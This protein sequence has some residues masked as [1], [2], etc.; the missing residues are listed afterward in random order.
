MNYSKNTLIVTF[1]DRIRVAD[2]Q[3]AEALLYKAK[4]FVRVRHLYRFSHSALV[5]V[6]DNKL[7]EF[8]EDMK[9]YDD[10]ERCQYNF[11]LYPCAINQQIASWSPAFNWGC[12]HIRSLH[13]LDVAP[14][15]G[16]GVKVAMIDSGMAPHPLLPAP[17]FT[18]AA[19]FTHL[20]PR[21]AQGN[22][23][24]ER[25]MSQ[26]L[27]LES[28]PSFPLLPDARPSDQADFLIR[29]EDQL[30]KFHLQ[31]WK[32]WLP[33]GIQWYND[34]ATA[35]TKYLTNRTASTA[36]SFKA[37]LL[38]P[39]PLT[40]SHAL[41]GELRRIST[42]SRSFVGETLSIEDT[43]GHGTQ[44]AGIIAGRAGAS[45]VETDP[46]KKR[47]LEKYET[48]VLGIVPNAEL[49]ILK[50]YDKDDVDNST[51][52]SLIRALEYG[53]EQN[54]DIVFCGLA[55]DTGPKGIDTKTAIALDRTINAL[56]QRNVFVVC[57]AGNNSKK[58][59]ELPA[60]CHSS[61]AISAVTTDSW[62]SILFADYSNSAG[63]REKVDFAAFG[64][65]ESL[66]ALT[67]GLD[68]GYSRVHGTS[69][70]AAIATG[71]IARDISKAYLAVRKGEYEDEMYKGVYNANQPSVPLM[72]PYAPPSGNPVS[73]V[74]PVAII[75]EARKK[76]LPINPYPPALIGSGL[77]V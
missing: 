47:E 48:D 45:S 74:K 51:V 63:P 65:D 75:R 7:D 77:I 42:R 13:G 2:E 35:Y 55:F 53:V 52:D 31:L 36:T 69:V 37:S 8:M 19:N 27:Q 6:G 43:H 10:V 68:F 23:N 70:A 38:P 54:A 12:Q 40:D 64:G 62:S 66:G 16:T 67:T 15:L 29:A 60:A 26:L 44:M 34:A 11:I 59:L 49:L 1:R 14:H 71:I 57:A 56:S 33:G 50:C 32:Q 18:Q 21:F 28:S 72:N 4:G 73:P 24:A 20:W 30:A 39:F 5:Q 41:C 17:S 61:L 3:A 9:N 25:I 22:P 58:E 46:N 76:A